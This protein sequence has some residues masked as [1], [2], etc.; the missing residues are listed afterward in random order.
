MNKTLTR[1]A[2][3]WLLIVVSLAAVGVGGWMI[4]GQVGTMTTTLM[5]GTATGVEVYVGQSLVVVGAVVLGAGLVGL[6]LSLGLVAARTLVA[7]PV[8]AAPAVE[9]EA[10]IIQD[11]T[12]ETV[13]DP[14]EEPALPTAAAEFA[15][16]QVEPASAEP[17]ADEGQKGSSG[18]IATAT[19][20]SVR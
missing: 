18:S 17:Q 8:T 5:D 10:S 11:E 15:E 1:S 20:S 19:N 13:S 4:A 16:P 6:L 9:Q 12:A 3:F 2:G 14:R 7:T